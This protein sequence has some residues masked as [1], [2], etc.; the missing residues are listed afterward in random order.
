[1][2]GIMGYNYPQMQGHFYSIQVRLQMGY[3]N[4]MNMSVREALECA[5]RASGRASSLMELANKTGVSYDLLKNIK[6]GKSLKPN[7][8]DANKIADFFGVSWNDFIAGRV[9]L[10]NDQDAASRDRD[11]A[12]IKSLVRQL[13]VPAHRAKVQAFAEALLQTEQA[14]KPSE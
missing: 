3:K 13:Q 7:A 4:P 9:P 5:M 10:E 6:Q 14:Q 12:E 1:M 8:I 2:V 11:A